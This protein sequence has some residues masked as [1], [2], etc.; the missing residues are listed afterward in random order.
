MK[1]KTLMQILHCPDCGKLLA[2]RFSLHHCKP[3]FIELSNGSRIVKRYRKGHCFA[4]VWSADTTGRQIIS[5]MA[6]GEAS[7]FPYNE[8]TGQFL[9]HLSTKPS[10][11]R[12]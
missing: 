8:S 9:W 2:S 12:K 7:F 5:A 3:P 10:H 4:A 11:F 6:Q 1:P